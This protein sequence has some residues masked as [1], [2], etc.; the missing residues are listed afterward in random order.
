[1]L[2]EVLARVRA[3]LRRGSEKVPGA[4]VQVADLEVDLAG[5]VVRRGGVV[6]ELTPREYAL[7]VLFVRRRGEVLSRTT[8]GEHVIDRAFETTSNAIDVSVAGLRAK[9]GPPPLI[10]TLRGAGYRFDAPGTA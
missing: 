6:L 3:L 4:L 7:L 5:H 1:M 9:L 10:H 2:K 8:I